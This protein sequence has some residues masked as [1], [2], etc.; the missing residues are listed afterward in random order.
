MKLNADFSRRV[1][2]RPADYRWVP[3]PMPGVERMMLDRIGEEVARATSLVRYAPGSRFSR[4]VHGGGE[5]FFVLEGVFADEHAEYPRGTYVRN[6]IGTAHTPRVGPEGCTIFVKLH[7]FE[8]DD[9]TPV[10]VDTTAAARDASGDT[11]VETLDLH[12]FGSE[13]VRLLRLAPGAEY[14][15]LAG[16]G[17]AEMLVLEGTLTGRGDDYPA[18]TWI[19]DPGHGVDL[20]AAGAEG[21]LLFLKTGYPLPSAD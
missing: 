13:R 2:I 4:H 5:E 1:V 11:G 9:T 21:A 16:A 10:V 12:S 19:R 17:V 7:Q 15:G 20:I 8:R 3:S 18:G 14:R 6:P